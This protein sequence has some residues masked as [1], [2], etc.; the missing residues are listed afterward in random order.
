MNRIPIHGAVVDEETRCAHYHG[1]WDIIAIKFACCGR[2]YPC[3]KCHQEAE[4]HEAVPWKREEWDLKAVYC[5]GCKQELSIRDYL[6]A[7]GTCPAC[8]RKFNPGCR[9]HW[10]L[11]FDMDKCQGTSI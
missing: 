8:G 4:N 11:Y 3:I 7:E 10:P 9:K 1:E 2:Y 5:G 6:S